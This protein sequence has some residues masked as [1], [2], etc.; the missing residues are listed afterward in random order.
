MNKKIIYSLPL[1]LLVISIIVISFGYKNVQK[2]SS[3]IKVIATTTQMFDITSNIGGDRIE[4]TGILGP[5]VDPH[6]Y[7]A[8]TQDAKMLNDAKLIVENGV[9]LERSIDKIV[10][11]SGSH[12][13]I[14]I[15]SSDVEILKGGPNDPDG[16]PHLWFSVPNVKKITNGVYDNLAK[17]DSA[18]KDYYLNHKN[19]YLA[20]LNELD[21]YIRGKINGVNPMDRKMVTNHDA[22][23]Y[24]AQEY[25]LNVIGSV[26]PNISTESQPSAK[27][28]TDLIN[29]IHDQK[30]KAI[31]TEK[32]INPKLID[33][34]AKSAGI[35]IVPSLYG[36]TL[37]ET[38]S[39][40]GTY[41]SMMKYNTDTI[42]ENIK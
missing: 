36:D 9:G 24:F 11:E 19:K 25:G 14:Y 23:G 4:L 16:D 12:S 15:A 41:I 22:F 7:E 20:S 5:N 26:I 6:E 31:F 10:K 17:I 30:V 37:G 39:T 3:K 35:K 21:S 8:T 29:K 2:S 27:E 32:S 34:I 28:T 42:V 13:Q 1:I 33:E 40:G 18:N 38:T